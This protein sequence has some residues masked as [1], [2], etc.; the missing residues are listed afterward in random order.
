M[1]IVIKPTANSN[2]RRLTGAESKWMIP[3]SLTYKFSAFENNTRL[4]RNGTFSTNL[5]KLVV[6]LLVF[7]MLGKG[8]SLVIELID[9]LLHFILQQR[10][11]PRLLRLQDRQA[12]QLL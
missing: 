8:L 4:F 2:F 10:E 6:E 5:S 9:I 1:S 3:Q 12:E 11:K 7:V